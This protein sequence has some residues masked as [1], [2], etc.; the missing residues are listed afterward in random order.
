[1]A[2]RTEG[3]LY[4]S[5]GTPVNIGDELDFLHSIHFA[6]STHYAFT[7]EMIPLATAVPEPSTLGL[8]EVGALGLTLRQRRNLR[9][10]P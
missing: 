3:T 10:R 4:F 7:Q 2:A 5:A 9:V 6:S 8:I 1:M